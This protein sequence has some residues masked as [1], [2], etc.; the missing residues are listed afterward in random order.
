MKIG[1]IN[2]HRGVKL[3]NEILDGLKNKD[4]EI[5]NY[6]TNNE[7]RVDYPAY[8]FKLG[9]AVINGDVDFGIA[10]CGS[11]I[12]VSVACNKVKGIRCGIVDTEEQV[13]HG[14][15]CDYI[16]I[17]ALRGE[18]MDCEKAISLIEIYIN[19][20]YAEDKTYYE[21]VKQIEKYELIGTY[22]L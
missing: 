12:G 6:G 1:I 2:D 16:N 20:D 10:I 11:G 15:S 4:Y 18:Y 21:R 22:E 7:D 9:E 8:S 17:L 3:K 5:I 14:K 13:K 19:T